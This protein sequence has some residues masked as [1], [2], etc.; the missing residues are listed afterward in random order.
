MKGCPTLA[1]V[2]FFMVANLL[3]VTA[4]AIPPGGSVMPQAGPQQPAGRGIFQAVWRP[5]AQDGGAVQFSDYV[6][7][8]GGQVVVPAGYGPPLVAGQGAGQNAGSVMPA[9]Y[10]YGPVGSAGCGCASCG[11]ECGPACCGCGCQPGVFPC[12]GYCGQSPACNPFPV[13]PGVY[14]CCPP[15]GTDPPYGY[16]GDRTDLAGAGC[17]GLD[18][19]GPHYFDVRLEA[20]AMTR[21]STYGPYQGFTVDGASKTDVVLDSD[22]LKYG[23][24]PGF[25]I[26]GRYDLGPLAVFEF[27]YMGIYSF[28]SSAEVKADAFFDDG[29][30]DLFSLWSGIFCN[31][32]FTPIEIQNE[33]GVHAQ[34]ERSTLQSIRI[35]SDLQTAEMSYR[36]YWVGYTPKISGT[37]LAGARYTRIGEGF[38]YHTFGGQNTEGDTEWLKYDTDTEN[39]LIGFQTGG[40]MWITIRQGLRIGGETKVGIYDNYHKIHTHIRASS[41]EDLDE[42][43]FDGGDDYD[44]KFRGNRVAFIGEAS[45]DVVFD[46]FPSWSLRAGYEV[47]FANSLALAGNNFN[48]GNIYNQV[49]GE[50]CPPIRKSFSNSNASALYHGA[51]LGLEYIW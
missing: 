31:D 1:T 32:K 48:K 13:G 27:G 40:D 9:G 25:R 8:D 21:V 49:P 15:P 18:Q 51:H 36:R 42:D 19:W 34:T 45:F 30:G 14:G 38:R 5:G 33:Q 50:D 29:E 41:S 39:N 10:A 22:D 12:E 37:F 28:D 11:S 7:A 2:A 3:C 20:V 6:N 16:D 43:L 24:E 23:F 46:F 17:L 44:E 35:R 26:M 47:L 4:L